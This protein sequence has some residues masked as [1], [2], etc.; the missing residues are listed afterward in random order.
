MNKTMH[1]YDDLFIY[2]VLYFRDDNIVNC[3][4]LLGVFFL[5]ILFLLKGQIISKWFLRSSISSKK[6]TNKFDLT[7][8]IPSIIPEDS[9]GAKQGFVGRKKY[10]D[11]DS[12]CF[13]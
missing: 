12:I 10:P 7:S 1:P 13:N 6:R 4:Q 11:Q 5:M 3:K 9:E 2:Y 8:M